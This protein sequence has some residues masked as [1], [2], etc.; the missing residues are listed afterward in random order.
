[1]FKFTV[2]WK[3]IQFYYL[4]LNK[5]VIILLT[6]ISHHKNEMSILVCNITILFHKWIKNANKKRGD[7]I[8]FG[9]QSEYTENNKLCAG[10]HV[11]Y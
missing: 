1:V 11:D 2:V 7:K 5:C 3:K 4:N 8:M 10:G 9:E 6:N